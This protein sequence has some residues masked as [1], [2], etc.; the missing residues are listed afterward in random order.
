M[1]QRGYLEGAPRLD[2]SVFG[3]THYMLQALILLDDGR[4]RVQVTSCSVPKTCTPSAVGTSRQTPSSQALRSTGSLT[5]R[6][7]VNLLHSRRRAR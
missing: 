3:Q 5:V 4:R 1:L 6:L 2:R 7:P